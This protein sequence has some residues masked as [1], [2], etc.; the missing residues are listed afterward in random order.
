MFGFTANEAKRYFDL[1]PDRWAAA[2]RSV[3]GY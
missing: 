3:R 2:H 1:L